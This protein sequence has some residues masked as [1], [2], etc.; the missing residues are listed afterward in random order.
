MAKGATK[1][2]KTGSTNPKKFD[3]SDSVD[4][5]KGKPNIMSMHKLPR[6]PSTQK[7]RV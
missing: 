6:N 2:M 7:R 4:R 5:G 1:P 3:P